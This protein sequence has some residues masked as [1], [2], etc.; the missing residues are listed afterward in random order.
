MNVLCMNAENV[1]V[2]N[3]MEFVSIMHV[4]HNHGKIMQ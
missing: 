3:C 4:Y 1:D 2:G